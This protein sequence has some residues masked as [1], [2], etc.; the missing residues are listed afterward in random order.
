MVQ[1]ADI[2]HTG[3]PGVPA[4]GAGSVPDLLNS[5]AP[6][7]G[8]DAEFTGAITPFTAIDG[9]SGTV[10]LNQGSGTGVYD[11]GTRSGWVL[12]QPGTASGE[13]V[14]FK[15]DVT[16]ADG[17][18]IVAYCAFALD[19]AGTASA[20]NEIALGIAVNDNDTGPFSGAAGQT[21]AAELDAEAS[22]AMRIIAFDGTSS[23]GE[24]PGSTTS[25]GGW[26]VRID[27]SGLVYRAFASRDGYA[28]SYIGTKTMGTA[29]NNVWLFAICGAT[30]A[31]RIVVACP[32]F[33]F[34]TALAIDPFPLT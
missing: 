30:M 33:R 23:L 1:H 15:Q 27:R 17:A 4:G 28:W 2:D 20:N 10:T 24:L 32:W 29:A 13:N 3:I 8:N 16:L 26:F 11:T 34:G 22:G 19:E 14:L 7:G 18:C 21:L 25:V 9:G 31:T 5:P 12:M 6:G